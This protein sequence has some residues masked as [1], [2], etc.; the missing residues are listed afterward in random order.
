MGKQRERGA[1]HDQAAQMRARLPANARPGVAPRI[2]ALL[3]LGRQVG[4]SAAQRML[5]TTPPRPAPDPWREALLRRVRVHTG[6]HVQRALDANQAEA[7]TLGDEIFLAGDGSD[8]HRRELLAHELAHVAQQRNPGPPAPVDALETEAVEAARL[9][10]RGR[11]A[12]VRL[13]A[14]PGQ[15][16]FAPKRQTSTPPPTLEMLQA[17]IRTAGGALRDTL[18]KKER[19]QLFDGLGADAVTALLRAV[20]ADQRKLAREDYQALLDQY[21]ETALHAATAQ[22]IVAQQPRRSA[23][24]PAEGAQRQLALWHTELQARMA[25][26]NQQRSTLFAA[27]RGSLSALMDRSVGLS[28]AQDDLITDLLSR[29]EDIVNKA[30]WEDTLSE[31]LRSLIRRQAQLTAYESTTSEVQGLTKERQTLQAAIQRQRRAHEPTA[32]LDEQLRAL[33]ATI[34]AREQTTRRLDTQLGGARG[35]RRLTRELEESMQTDEQ[36][37]EGL[38]QIEA[39]REPQVAQALPRATVEG[40]TTDTLIPP[41]ARQQIYTMALEN[42]RRGFPGFTQELHHQ[43]V[44]QYSSSIAS[45]RRSLG[46]SVG[47]VGTYPTHGPGQFDVNAGAGQ[48]VYMVAQSDLDLARYLE[49]ASP[50]APRLYRY[51]GTRV[52]HI[53]RVTQEEDVLA[54]LT[55]GF[56]GRAVKNQ[57][58]LTQLGVRQRRPDAP[59][60]VRSPDS[61]RLLAGLLFENTAPVGAL[62]PEVN[63]PRTA[64]RDLIERQLRAELA[65]RQQ[66]FI[67]E[68]TPIFRSVDASSGQFGR[69]HMFNETGIKAVLSPLAPGATLTLSQRKELQARFNRFTSQAFQIVDQILAGETRVRSDA[70]QLIQTLLRRRLGVEHGAPGLSIRAGSSL[71]LD[72]TYEAV[73]SQDG[74]APLEPLGVTIRVS[75]VHMRSI[76]EGLTKDQFFDRTA[77][78]GEV[79][80]TGNAISPHVHMS[81]ELVINGMAVSWL[82]PLDF[83]PANGPIRL[84]HR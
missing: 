51:K 27:A 17:R 39:G 73:P 33:R 52:Q 46:F 40:A 6:P 76:P 21:R 77:L 37:Q 65:S 64:L 75:Y 1:R 67:P 30:Q 44:L 50:S 61:T 5:A 9:L 62:P 69:P 48:P 58:A 14:R 42:M 36:R 83:F 71:T 25:Q 26:L 12:Q 2:A 57:E 80:S 68:A 70:E 60:V 28:F 7:A 31:R 56:F 74:V 72:H 29:S 4:N 13:S 11:G 59:A 53:H 35:R 23:P 47:A 16:L 43:L 41:E 79:G 19:Q 55:Y 15:R 45:D 54:K 63:G 3:E 84:P 34:H 20:T 81:V 18:T 8:R 49:Q 38:A 82:N 32:E 22:W 10:T 66:I 24:T 78:L